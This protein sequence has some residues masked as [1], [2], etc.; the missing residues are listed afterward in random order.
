MPRTWPT[1]NVA[2]L[3]AMRVRPYSGSSLDDIADAEDV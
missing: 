2:E 3:I 1:W